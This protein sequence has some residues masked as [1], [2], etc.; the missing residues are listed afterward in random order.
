[1][2]EGAIFVDKWFDH[3]VDFCKGNEE[4]VWR[5]MTRREERGREDEKREGE[6]GEKRRGV[7]TS[8]LRMEVCRDELTAR[9]FENEDDHIVA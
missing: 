1:M 8:E 7:C 2:R 3:Y 6:D 9:L 5:E 4:R